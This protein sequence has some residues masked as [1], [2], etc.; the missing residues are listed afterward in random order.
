MKK[1]IGLSAVVFAIVAFWLVPVLNTAKETTYV[2][3][4][5]NTEAKEEADTSQIKTAMRSPRKYKTEMLSSEDRVAHMNVSKFSR[6][7]QFNPMDSIFLDSLNRV[8]IDQ[9]DSSLV[10]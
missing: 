3:V 6:A 7:I 5:E 4:Y 8:T 1:I 9:S 2:R 10:P